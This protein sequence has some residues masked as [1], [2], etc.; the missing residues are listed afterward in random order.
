MTSSRKIRVLVVDDSETYRAFLSAKLVDSGFFEVAGE[1]ADG[2]AAVE[3]VEQ[4]KPDVVALDLKMPGTGGVEAVVR[5]MATWPTP[6]VI[7]TNAAA[8]REAFLALEAG[9][10]EVVDKN[11][12]VEL[13][14]TAL[15][16][17]S[18]V[19]VV[20]R[21]LGPD[22]E[23]LPAGRRFEVVGIGG[24]TGGPAALARIL[25]HLPR[26]LP[27]PVLVAQH[28]APSFVAGLVEWLDGVSALAVTT[29]RQGQALEPGIVYLP[30]AGSEISLSQPGFLGLAATRDPKGPTVDVLFESLARVYRSRAL[31]VLLT[32]MGRDGAR[33]LSSVRASGGTTIAQDEASCVVFGMPKAA[34]ELGAVTHVLPLDEIP[35]VLAELLGGEG[36]G[37]E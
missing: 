11:S 22:A 24:S 15:H 14:L 10:L 31:A 3:L 32:G 19:R 26:K 7:V 12:P 21:R 1:A 20:R 2:R 33:G 9:A 25:E 8:S 37:P 27:V 28:L 18:E 34:M 23:P 35:R 30:P 29:G 17:M 5:I 6:I 13:V 16:L 36:S 4:R